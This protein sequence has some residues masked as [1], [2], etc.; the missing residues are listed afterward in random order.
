MIPWMFV[1]GIFFI[2]IGTVGYFDATIW[3]FIKLPGNPKSKAII[4]LIL[5]IACL[6]IS[7]WYPHGIHLSF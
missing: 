2:L 1:I 5:G 4:V 6:I 3:E 7:Y